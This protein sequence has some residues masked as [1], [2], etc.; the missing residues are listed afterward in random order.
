MSPRSKKEYAQT[1]RL[2]YKNATRHE[3]TIILDEFCATCG[4]HRKHAVRVLTD[5]K[6]LK[7]LK[8]KKRSKY[9]GRP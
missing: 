3:K 8:T 2:R 6:H 9:Q 4:Y 7:K 1:V 5:P